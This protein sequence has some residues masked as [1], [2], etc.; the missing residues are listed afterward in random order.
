MAIK[1]GLTTLNVKL[2]RSLKRFLSL[3]FDLRL[4]FSISL[5]S[6]FKNIFDERDKNLS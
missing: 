4:F 6:A 3:S 5:K 1:F 2:L